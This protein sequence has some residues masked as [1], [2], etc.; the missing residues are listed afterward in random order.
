MLRPSNYNIPNNQPNVG[1][2]IKLLS[3]LSKHSNRQGQSL[4]ASYYKPTY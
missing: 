4:A 2:T 3:Q 1:L